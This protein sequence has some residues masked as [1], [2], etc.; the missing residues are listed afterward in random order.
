MTNSLS[1]INLGWDLDSFWHQVFAMSHLFS[2]PFLL[3]KVAT[4]TM[5]LLCLLIFFEYQSAHCPLSS[6]STLLEYEAFPVFCTLLAPD[7]VF[8]IITSSVK[9]D[10][11]GI[12]MNKRQ[13]W[14]FKSVDQTERG[15]SFVYVWTLKQVKLPIFVGFNEV[16]FNT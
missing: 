14:K 11:W 5:H 6:V 1:W 2:L 13:T 3:S 4:H 10:E 8:Q 15:P 7:I 12:A 9:W 16:S